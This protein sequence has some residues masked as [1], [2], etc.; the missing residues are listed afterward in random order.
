MD[1]TAIRVIVLNGGSSSGKTSIARSLQA[2]L[3]RPWLRF[4]VDDF[5]EALPPGLLVS[6]AGIEVGERGEVTVGEDFRE[7]EAAWRTGLAAMARAGAGVILDDAFL[8]G[9]VSQ[10]RVRAGLEGLTVL[11]VGVHC[12]PGIATGREVIRGDRVAGMAAMQAEL[13]HR[14][15]F[16]DIE[17]DTSHT[18]A[19]DCARA[20]AARAF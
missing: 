8:G 17:V 6:G 16:Y 19:L 1:G 11:W 4:S 2:I 13:V 18:E 7:L 14:G 9:A 10:Q 5:V 15:V 3:P 12:D 20:I